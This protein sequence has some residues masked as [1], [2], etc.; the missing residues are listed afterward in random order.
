MDT[1]ICGDCVVELRVF[2]GFISEETAEIL[3][4]SPRTD[5]T[6]RWRSNFPECTLN[7]AWR[8]QMGLRLSF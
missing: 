3:G 2:G 5:R 4:I 8:I 1:P 7:G 6:Q